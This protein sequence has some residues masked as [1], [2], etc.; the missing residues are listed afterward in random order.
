[1]RLACEE[2]G[3]LCCTPPLAT[4]MDLPVWLFIKVATVK[5]ELAELHHGKEETKMCKI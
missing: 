4:L 5:K 1:M 3:L 2:P